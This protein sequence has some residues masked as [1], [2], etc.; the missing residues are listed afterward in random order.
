MARGLT[1]SEMRR[2]SHS[3]LIEAQAVLFNDICV[4][5]RMNQIKLTFLEHLLYLLLEYN[6][7]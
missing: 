6:A 4:R 1:A 2:A 5:Q 7:F 3:D